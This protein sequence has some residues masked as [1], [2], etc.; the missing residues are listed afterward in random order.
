MPTK[1]S[2]KFLQESN[3]V[4]GFPTTEEAIKW[5][6]AVCG[7]PVKSTWVK[8]IKAGNFTGW[9]MLNKHNVAK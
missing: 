4:Y 7:Y 1:Q 6:H 8:A 5:M 9:P 2:K 3:S